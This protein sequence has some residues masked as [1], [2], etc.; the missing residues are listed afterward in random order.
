MMKKIFFLSATALAAVLAML[1]CNKQNPVANNTVPDVTVSV[2]LPDGFSEDAV[3]EGEVTMVS[4]STSQALT[5]KA[6][7]GTARFQG[8][9]YGVYDISAELSVSKADFKE[10]APS[11]AGESDVQISGILKEVVLGPASTQTAFSLTTDWNV[12]SPLVFSRIYNFGT[13]NLAGKAYN[14]DKYVEIFNNSSEVQYLDGLY[15]GEAWGSAPMASTMPEV[16]KQPVVYMQRISRIPGSGKDYP[17]QP[18][19]SVVI[20]Q[21]A[22]NHIDATVVTNTVDLSAADFECYVEGAASFFP[23]DNADV[24]NLTPDVYQAGSFQAKLM[25]TQGFI[26]VLF[27]ATEAEVE[28]MT[29][30]LVPG[31]DA[32]GAQ[33]ASYVLELPAAKVIDLVDMMRTGF[34]SRGGKHVPNTMDAGFAKI[35]QQSVA[36]RKISRTVG[37][38]IVLKDTNNS[39]NDFV[40]LT[41]EQTD[42]AHLKARDYSDARIQPGY[43]QAGDDEEADGE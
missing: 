18:G 27:R 8:V 26:P 40:E 15:I 5:A 6:S 36:A 17:V 4:R 41:S 42:G 24:P 33:Y 30:T 37:D 14:I 22:K 29:K 1:S 20:A 19:K 11:L 9:P 12:A 35:N 43:G 39:T 32:Y 10:M 34:E 16:D 28:A 2:S 21:N 25:V 23:S 31:T 3:F 38:R 13:L 7:A